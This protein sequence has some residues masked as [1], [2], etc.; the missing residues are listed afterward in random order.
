MSSSRRSSNVVVG[1][2][3]AWAVAPT[4]SDSAYSMAATI[5]SI[6]ANAALRARNVSSRSLSD[7]HVVEVRLGDDSVSSSRSTSTPPTWS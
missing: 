5:A 7:R 3:R 1:S 2:G 4:P 6:H